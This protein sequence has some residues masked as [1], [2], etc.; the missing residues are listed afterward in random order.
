[1]GSSPTPGASNCSREPNTPPFGAVFF[2]GGQLIGQLPAP[3]VL[4]VPSAVTAKMQA[5]ERETADL[6]AQ[7]WTETHHDKSSEAQNSAMR[8]RETRWMRPP[9][10]GGA[11]IE[12]AILDTGAELRPVGIIADDELILIEP[13]GSE[14]LVATTRLPI[15]GMSV[16][17]DR[18]TVHDPER[19]NATGG[20]QWTFDL[21][22]GK[23]S[24]VFTVKWMPPQDLNRSGSFADVLQAKI[25]AADWL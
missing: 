5:M 11:G 17:K 18:E 24:L 15:S 22:A 20:R 14:D 21:G 19:P 9:S 3:E 16:A 2:V 10:P 8:E 23:C 4:D 1:M 7:E 6:I 25:A 13:K 12:W